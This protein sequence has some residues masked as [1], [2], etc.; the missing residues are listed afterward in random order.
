M[1]GSQLASGNLF[2]VTKSAVI[3]TLA[4]PGRLSNAWPSGSS[5]GW[6]GTYVVGPPTSTPTVNF[7]AFGLGVEL[8]V[9][10]IDTSLAIPGDG[11]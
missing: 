10:D 5:G 11:T 7:T 8:T 3:N 9:I 1:T 4:T 6:L 2:N